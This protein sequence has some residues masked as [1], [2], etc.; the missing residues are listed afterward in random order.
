MAHLIFKPLHIVKPTYSV[1]ATADPVE[2][3]T[4]EHLIISH[5]FTT[6]GDDNEAC[7]TFLLSDLVLGE[8]VLA[9][10]TTRGCFELGVVTGYTKGWYFSFDG[11]NDGSRM[12]NGLLLVRG[13]L[14]DAARARYKVY[15]DYTSDGDGPASPLKRTDTGGNYGI[16]GCPDLEFW[17]R[18]GVE[19]WL[20][21]GPE[22]YQYLDETPEQL[23]SRILEM[24]HDPHAAEY[25]PIQKKA[26][27]HQISML[28]S[29]LPPPARAAT[30]P[31]KAPEQLV[32][33]RAPRK[34]S[35]TFCPVT[36][37]NKHTYNEVYVVG[38]SLHGPVHAKT[39]SVCD[40]TW[41]I[42][43]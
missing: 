15:A 33:P 27:Q 20:Y 28:K 34:P 29:R 31:S 22:D 1:G 37:D 16:G 17:T 39:C 36:Q 25:T 35:D 26:L 3:I 42:D 32:P 19:P 38:Q 5:F 21:V 18:N 14:A 12:W 13:P 41:V 7:D 30:P 9:G 24:E 40:H 4:D 11:L 23:R 6:E 8:S 43:H 2:K 10:Y